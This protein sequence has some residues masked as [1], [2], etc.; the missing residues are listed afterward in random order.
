MSDPLK[1][2]DANCCL[3]PLSVPL[4]AH[5]ENAGELSRAMERAGVDQALVYHALSKEHAPKAGNEQLLKEVRE[6]PGLYPSFAVLP[7]HTGD[8]SAGPAL[9]AELDA[10]GVRAV[11]VFPKS[12]N[13]PLSQ[14]SAGK[15]LATLEERPIPLFL[16]FAETSCDQAYALATAHPG[17]PVVLTGWPFRLS[18]LVY[19]LLAETENLHF[20]IS[21]FQLHAGIEDI[22]AKFGARRLLFGSAAP[23]LDP[24]PSV[25]AVQYAR[26]SEEEKAMIAG[27]NLFALL[28][29]TP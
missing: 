17:L 2:F 29:L 6:F 20:E 24:A 8:M 7:A 9:L 21:S 1:F 28:G 27:E 19:A 12:Q 11:R 23:H 26:I 3:G 14:W 16:D 5:F 22:C 13:W 18:R 4:P 10:G 15:L 25:M